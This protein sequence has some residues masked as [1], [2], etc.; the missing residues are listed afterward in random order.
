MLN[1]TK[2]E[3]K[4]GAGARP[5]WTNWAAFIQ[6]A[7]ELGEYEDP[8]TKLKPLANGLD[9][10]MEWPQPVKHLLFSQILQ[11]GGT[12][13]AADGTLNLATQQAT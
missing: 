12:Y 5:S 8:Q 13:W 10:A 1:V 7:S 11:R 9:I 6:Q 3:A 2:Y 4:F